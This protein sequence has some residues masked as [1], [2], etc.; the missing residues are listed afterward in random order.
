MGMRGARR[1]EGATRGGGTRRRAVAKMTPL[2]AANIL[3][4]G[5]PASLLSESPSP[6]SPFAKSA[7]CCS[8]DSFRSETA[9]QDIPELPQ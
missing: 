7:N 5:F 1:G 3:L 6:Y 9:H 4:C 2:I 8:S